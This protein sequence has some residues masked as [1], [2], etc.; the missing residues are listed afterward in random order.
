MLK[1]PVVDTV[2]HLRLPSQ[3]NPTIQGKI[4]ALRTVETEVETRVIPS[5]E[6]NHKL[7][8]VLDEG[9]GTT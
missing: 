1:I 7:A 2:A 3:L 9:I 6:R 5:R 8:S 4:N